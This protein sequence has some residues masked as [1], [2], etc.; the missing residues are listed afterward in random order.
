MILKTKSTLNILKIIN[1]NKDVSF[2][3]F[4][5]CSP[6]ALQFPFSIGL[7]TP[8]GMF[9]RAYKGILY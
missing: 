3:V 7:N 4:Q 8:Q 2:P 9:S 1:I 6:C 5:I